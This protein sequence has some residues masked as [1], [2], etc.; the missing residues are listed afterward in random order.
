MNKKR[1]IYYDPLKKSLLYKDTK[2]VIY[3]E[4]GLGDVN[5]IDVLEGKETFE[6]GN[7]FEVEDFIREELE[8][9]DF[10]FVN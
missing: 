3:K 4:R 8:I 6:D 5:L 2:E 1:K 10:I 9:V 7:R